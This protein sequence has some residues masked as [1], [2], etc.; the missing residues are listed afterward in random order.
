R[1]DNHP[2]SNIR[3]LHELYHLANPHYHGLVTVPVLWD[4]KRHTIVSNKSADI[5]RMFN[6][7]FNHITDND[8]E[9]YFADIQDEINQINEW[10]YQ[11]LNNAVYK[12][13]FAQ[14][15]TDYEKA[16]HQVFNALDEL[17]EH[18]SE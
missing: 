13:G 18:L 6:S 16:Y 1:D 14:N 12:A 2:V 4:K 5:I 15:Q 9:F 8:Y 17:E 11:E 10:V 3:Y 7:A